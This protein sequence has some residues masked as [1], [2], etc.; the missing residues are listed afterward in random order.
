MNRNTQADF[1]E[2]PLPPHGQAPGVAQRKPC[3][4]CGDPTLVATLNHYGARC[5]T[6]YEAYCR[7]PLPAL[8]PQIRKPMRSL[9][10]ETGGEA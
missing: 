7:E 2:T 6:C 3:M 5:F 4:R 8:A 9:L 1:D 10:D